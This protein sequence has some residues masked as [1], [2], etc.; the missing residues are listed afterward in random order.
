MQS[1]D[2]SQCQRSIDFDIKFAGE[3]AAE[4]G[5]A[6]DGHPAVCPGS[7]HFHQIPQVIPAL[8][9]RCRDTAPGGD[10]AVVEKQL[11]VVCK[12]QVQMVAVAV[13]LPAENRVVRTRLGLLHHDENARRVAAQQ[14]GSVHC[15]AKHI[16]RSVELDCCLAVHSLSGQG[17]LLACFDLAHIVP[18]RRAICPRAHFAAILRHA[19]P[20]EPEPQTKRGERCAVEHHRPDRAGRRRTALGIGRRGGNSVQT[21]LGLGP[22]QFVRSLSV[23]ADQLIVFEKIDLGDGGVARRHA[24]SQP[25]CSARREGDVLGRRG[26]GDVRA[27]GHSDRHGSS[28][29]LLAVSIGHG[30]D[31]FVVTGAHAF[32]SSLEGCTGK[33]C[34]H[35]AVGEKLHLAHRSIRGVV[36]RRGSER[37]GRRGDELRAVRRRSQLDRRRV[38]DG[39]AHL[40]GCDFALI[41]LD[42]HGEHCRRGVGISTAHPADI[43]EHC[44]AL[45]VL[46]PVSRAIRFCKCISLVYPDRLDLAVGIVRRD[47]EGE[48]ARHRHEVARRRRGA[49]DDRRQVAG[50]EGDLDRR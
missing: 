10:V 2:A 34:D 14:P 22:V 46:G 50:G 35:F 36:G 25:G 29:D 30:C 21:G 27:L 13:R 7:V 8:R 17:G 1:P 48:L 33:V 5:L 42:V 39:E 18:E 12:Q 45:V 40:L 37:D 20:V 23:G 49:D 24:G 41:V 38:V 32:P 19:V 9:L 3:C 26:Q 15:G 11:V 4:H 31:D 6:R 43:R 47:R 44:L 28:L 16:I